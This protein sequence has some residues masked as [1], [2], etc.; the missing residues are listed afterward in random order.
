MRTWF[1]VTLIQIPPRTQSTQTQTH[2]TDLITK[3]KKTTV[4]C[5]IILTTKPT[6][7]HNKHI[8]I[9]RSIYIKTIIKS[10]I[11]INVNIYTNPIDLYISLWQIYSWS[12]LFPTIYY[13]IATVRSENVFVCARNILKFDAHICDHKTQLY[14]TKTFIKTLFIHFGHLFTN[15][16]FHLNRKQ[17]HTCLSKSSMIFL[18]YVT[19]THPKS[20]YIY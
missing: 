9:Y 3:N 7:L 1:F 20:S 13:Y 5:D 14:K 4:L 10:H 8:N 11:Y 12:F 15:N 16:I 17:T 19:H 6:L 18:T 2:K